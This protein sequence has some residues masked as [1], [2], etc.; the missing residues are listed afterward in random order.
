LQILI[1]PTLP[2]KPQPHATFRE[3]EKEGGKRIK[4]CAQPLIMRVCI[5]RGGGRREEGGGVDAAPIH[6]AFT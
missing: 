2:P 1:L 4:I 6:F 3:E 5:T